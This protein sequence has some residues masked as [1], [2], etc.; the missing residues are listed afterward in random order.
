[1]TDRDTGRSKGLAFIEFE[2]AKEAAKALA[3]ENGNDLEGREIRVDYSG[4]SKGPPKFD[5]S[6]PE[7][8]TVFVGN[9]GFR[10][11]ES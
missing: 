2:K 3:S 10:T 4:Q 7:S 8:G 9:L 5:G 1:M 6:A 11:S